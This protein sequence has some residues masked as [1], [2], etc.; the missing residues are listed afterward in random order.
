MADATLSIVHPPTFVK[1]LRVLLVTKGLDLG[2]IE[3]VVTDLALGLSAA[4]VDVEVALVNSER[5]RLAHVV[6]D[7]GI[8]VHRLDG[9]DLI[10]I[11]AARRLARLAGDPAY[12]IVHVHGPLP[13][14]LVR[15]ATRGRRNVTTSHTPW[16]SL[17][18][19]TRA[20]WRATA[21]LDSATIVVSSTVAESLPA[22]IGQRAV[23]VPHG[24]DPARVEAALAAP[25][26]AGADGPA[27]GP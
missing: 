1:Q 11:G 6:T 12:D 21:R 22:R 17:R 27:T 18:P 3:R 4:G 2:G 16:R 26:R 19:L 10:G 20:G 9:T 14:I 8:V 13:S 24:I 5:D 15:L 23:V 7:A 25:D